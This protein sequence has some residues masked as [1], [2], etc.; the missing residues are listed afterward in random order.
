MLYSDNIFIN[1]NST[2]LSNKIVLHCSKLKHNGLIGRT[3]LR[4][5]VIHIA[6]VIDIANNNVRNRKVI[7]LLHMN[8]LFGIFHYFNFG[9]DGDSLELYH[10]P[11]EF[12]YMITL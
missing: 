5:G 9:T 3:Y 6:G 12:R 4:N 1:E 8:M 11:I 2:Q 10:I 7:K